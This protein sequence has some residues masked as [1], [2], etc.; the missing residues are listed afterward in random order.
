MPGAHQGFKAAVTAMCISALIETGGERRGGRAAALDRGEAWLFEHLPKVRRATP[1]AFYN[2]WTHA[3][4]IQALV[5][6]LGR[7]PDDADRR[8]RIRALIAQQIDMLGP[9][10][11]G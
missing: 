1:D 11:G 2:V 5:R 7:K 9:L 6:M 8:E 4:G 10:R 3:Y